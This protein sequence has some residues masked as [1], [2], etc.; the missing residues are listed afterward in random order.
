L[1]FIDE[2]ACRGLDTEA[3]GEQRIDEMLLLEQL[4]PVRQIERRRGPYGS[5][6]AR[7]ERKTYSVK[8]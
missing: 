5:P 7:A 3:V 6:Q 1:R 4:V 8:R 2:R